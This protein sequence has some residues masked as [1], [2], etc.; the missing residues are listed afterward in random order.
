MVYADI[1]SL[2]DPSSPIVQRMTGAQTITQEF[3]FVGAILMETAIAMALLSRVL[4]YR[5]NRW[6]NIIAGAVN[7][8]AVV[9]GGTTHL[10]YLF[11]ATIEVVCLLLIIWFSWKWSSTESEERSTATS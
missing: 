5:A 11:F 3:L 8:V 6:A 4:K 7:I 1:L 2:M 9:T 10:Y